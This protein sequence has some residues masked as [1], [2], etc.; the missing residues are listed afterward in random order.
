MD[1]ADLRRFG[2]RLGRARTRLQNA[3]LPVADVASACGYAIFRHFSA[4]CRSRFGTTPGA[5]RRHA[6]ATVRRTHDARR[7][8]AQP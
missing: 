8:P 5:D 7:H 4:A 2:L 6:C 1:L 3:A